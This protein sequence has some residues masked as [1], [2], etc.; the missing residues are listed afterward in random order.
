MLHIKQDIQKKVDGLKEEIVKGHK[1]CE[2]TGYITDPN[3]DSLASR[4]KCMIV[5]R[6]LARLARAGIPIDYWDLSF[7]TL[8]IPN[9]IKA[10]IRLYIDN[11]DRAKQ[12]GLGMLFLGDNGVGKTSAGCEIAKAAILSGYDVRYFTLSSYVDS[13]FSRDDVSLEWYASGQFLLIDEVDKCSVKIK[14]A[15]DDVFRKFNNRGKCLIMATN[16]NVDTIDQALGKSILSLLKRRCSFV[17][18]DGKD[19]SETV[20]RQF[21]DRLL[22]PVDYFSPVIWK[23]AYN[24]ERNSLE[25]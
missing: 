1:P 24:F 21:E 22:N 16:L 3:D 20:E 4:C 10:K 8:Q 6:Y 19:Y 13:L 7:D 15:L 17:T 11:I 9:E 18:F 5:F 14:N 23:S 2:G 12:R 25:S